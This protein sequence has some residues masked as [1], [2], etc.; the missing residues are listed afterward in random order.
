[1]QDS[2]VGFAVY[3]LA[4]DSDSTYLSEENHWNRIKTEY[5]TLMFVR[6]NVNSATA[7]Y[8]NCDTPREDPFFGDKTHCAERNI[9]VSFRYYNAYQGSGQKSGAYIFRPENGTTYTKPYG[10]YLGFKC[11]NNSDWLQT[12]EIDTDK[13]NIYMRMIKGDRLG[14]QVETKF[15]GV[16]LSNN[17]TEVTLDI[18]AYGFNNSGT[19]FTDSN[20]LQLQKR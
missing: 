13:G 12:F 8:V 5:Q 18:M 20:G 9:T 15:N 14:L 19:F 6:S 1:M 3:K 4:Y 16:D 10:Q 2:K 17:G 11:Y 7:W